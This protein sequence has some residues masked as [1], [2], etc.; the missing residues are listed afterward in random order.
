M[1]RPNRL[2]EPPMSANPAAPPAVTTLALE[3]LL[4]HWREDGKTV[5]KMKARD[6]L[7]QLSQERIAITSIVEYLTKALA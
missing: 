5:D 3:A 2:A 4:T 1:Q 6:E 7:F